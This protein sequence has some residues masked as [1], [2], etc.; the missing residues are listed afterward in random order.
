MSAN[1]LIYN[2]WVRCCSILTRLLLDWSLRRTRYFCL[3]QRKCGSE[4]SREH[5]HWR[6]KYGRGSLSNRDGS[7]AAWRIHYETADWISQPP[8][9]CKEME[10][11]GRRYQLPSYL[12][13]QRYSKIQPDTDAIRAFKEIYRKYGKKTSCCM[14]KTT[15]ALKAY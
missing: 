7:R 3:F 13:W 1:R 12:A 8:V 5:Y 9:P 10:V 15:L 6:C 11:D 2:I 14:C 4:Y